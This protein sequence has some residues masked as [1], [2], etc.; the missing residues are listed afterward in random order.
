MSAEEMDKVLTNTKEG[1]EQFEEMKEAYDGLVREYYRVKQYA[2]DQ[3]SLTEEFR[4]TN[5]CIVLLNYLE[6]NERKA[7]MKQNKTLIERCNEKEL[8]YNEVAH[9]YQEL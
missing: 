4:N 8:E 3:E 6:V 5:H 9:Y 2:M 1:C 7:Q